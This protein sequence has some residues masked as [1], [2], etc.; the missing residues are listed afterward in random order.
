MILVDSS[1]WIPFF[2]GQNT[3][4]VQKL[5]KALG[6]NIVLIGDLILTEV[7]QGFRH[8]KDYLS[9]MNLLTILEI[10]TLGGRDNSIRSA[11]NYRS[12]RRQG[13][14]V[15][16]TIDI[17]IGT[18]CMENRIQLLHNDKDFYPMEMYLGL[19]VY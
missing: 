14:T 2:N 5:D 15:R 10:R 9:A 6:E 12:L 17:F 4:Q 7:L 1:V 11:Q 19:D 3:R 16:K 8:D 18:Y 13:V